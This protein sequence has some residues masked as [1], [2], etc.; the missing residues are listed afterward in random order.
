MVPYHQW[1]MPKV[2]I[3]RPTMSLNFQIAVHFFKIMKLLILGSL[4]NFG[5]EIL[6]YKTTYFSRFH[7]RN[8]D[9]CT[10]VVSEVVHTETRLQQIPKW[11]PGMQ[12]GE[13]RSSVHLRLSCTRD[14]P[15]RGECLSERATTDT[16]MHSEIP[17]MGTHPPPSSLTKSRPGNWAVAVWNG[18]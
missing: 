10:W 1:V 4:Q 3:F 13:R 2:N 8:Q 18:S 7:I 16:I 12:L 14:I 5:Y 15:G 9:T 17:P 11:N 6:V